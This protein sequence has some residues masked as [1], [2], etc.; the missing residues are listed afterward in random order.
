MA[1]FYSSPDTRNLPILTG[2]VSFKPDNDTTYR[3]LGYVDDL[4]INITVESKPKKAARGGL[5]KTVFTAYISGDAT[6]KM[7]LGELTPDNLAL[8][9]LGDT[10]TATDGSIDVQMLSG[11]SPSGYLKFVADNSFGPQ[12]NFESYVTL[13]PA[14]DLSLLNLNGDFSTLPVQGTVNEDPV[15]GLFP[16]FN[17]PLN[18]A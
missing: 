6:F 10:S 18:K 9:L 11:L 16:K 17:F 4:S 13:G 14:G 5:V 2:V 3:D 1:N 7:T 8:F 12:F 15:T